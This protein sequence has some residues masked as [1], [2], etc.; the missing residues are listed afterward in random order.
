MTE[1]EILQLLWEKNPQTV[2]EINEAINEK[3]PSGYTTTLK[4]LQIMT[5]KGFVDRE[6]KGK[7][8]LY[9][10]LLEEDDTQKAI[11]DRLLDSV[12]MGSAQKLIL[13]TLGSYKTSKEEIREIRKMLD[14]I[15]KQNK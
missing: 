1:L 15:D 12:F 13:K 6:V 3:R 4:I 8:H 2:K 10:P 11:I 14:K 7:K 5:N 9:Y